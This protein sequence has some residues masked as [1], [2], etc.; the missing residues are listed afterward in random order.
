[1]SSDRSTASFALVTA[2][3]EERRVV[4]HDLGYVAPAKACYIAGSGLDV[5]QVGY[6]QDAQPYG[7]DF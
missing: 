6:A 1:M 3:E 4:S 5:S 7:L 2:L